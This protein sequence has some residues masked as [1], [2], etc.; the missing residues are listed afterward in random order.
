M[1]VPT[2]RRSTTLAL[3]GASLAVG[4]AIASAVLVQRRSSSN[5]MDWN[6]RREQR[7]QR[8]QAAAP[9]SPS[10]SNGMPKPAAPENGETPGIPVPP[11]PPTRITVPEINIDLGDFMSRG[12]IGIINGARALY[13]AGMADRA[14]EMLEGWIDSHPDAVYA[15]LH[16]FWLLRK[17]GRSDEAKS[18]IQ[19]FVEEHGDKD[20][21][22]PIAKVF[23]GQL[24]PEQLLAMARSMRGNPRARLCESYYYLGILH[25]TDKPPRLEDAKNEFTQAIAQ[26]TNDVEL[27]Y[28][29]EELAAL[30][31]TPRR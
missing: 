16:R 2:Y 4:A 5:L 27:G 19:D 20:W 25:M 7:R 8:A 13:R 14:D 31:R 26:R 21:P 1:V 12:E 23:A 10:W 9:P 30:E 15:H 11:V 6:Q 28:A 22:V 24:K 18:F 3:A 17:L 29:R